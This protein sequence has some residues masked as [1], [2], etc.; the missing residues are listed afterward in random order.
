MLFDLP[1]DPRQLR[2]VIRRHPAVARR[3]HRAFLDFMYQVGAEN[4]YIAKY[5]IRYLHEA[6][7]A[8]QH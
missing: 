7:G 5:D 6:L 1:N 8:R 4:G 3:M 2:N